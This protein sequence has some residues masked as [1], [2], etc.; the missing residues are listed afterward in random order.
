MDKLKELEQLKKEYKEIPVPKDGVAG[1]QAA[2]ERAVKKKRLKKR[3]GYYVVTAA[4]AALVILVMPK[5]M[6]RGNF[7]ANESM[8][9]GVASMMKDT[10]SGGA[11]AP[12]SNDEY[13]YMDAVSQEK[14]EA[15]SEKT[16][17]TGGR[18]GMEST[19]DATES[20]TDYDG[21]KEFLLDD[22][23]VRIKISE[24]IKKQVNS[25]TGEERERIEKS[26]IFWM[27]FDCITKEQ[28]YYFNQEGTLV[29]VFR[30]EGTLSGMKTLEFVIPD[31]VWK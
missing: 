11:A 31:E 13:G 6:F 24:E 1:V 10:F 27:D 14:E 29:I 17:G 22:A 19:T 5:D 28:E 20:A 2:M 26:G 7:A 3:L 9:K 23:E 16:D 30:A 21:Q 12:E 8:N 18:F 25:A 15:S 4:A